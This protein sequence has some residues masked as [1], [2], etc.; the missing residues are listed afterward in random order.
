MILFVD[1]S[2]YGDAVF[3][4][5]YWKKAIKPSEV[6]S[7]FIY[8]SEKIIINKSNLGIPLFFNDKKYKLLLLIYK[9][10]IYYFVIIGVSVVT[11]FTKQ[12]INIIFNLHQPFK[13]WNLLLNFSNKRKVILEV[14]VHDV[15]EFDTSNYPKFIMSNNKKIISYS[16]SVILHSGFEVFKEIYGS[17]KELIQLPFP[18]RLP[19]ANSVPLIPTKYYYIP[20]RYRKEKGFDFVIKNWP[21]DEAKILVISTELPSDLKEEVLLNKNILYKPFLVESDQFQNLVVNSYACILMYNSGTNSG[22][23]ATIIANNIRCLVS[24]LNMFT[25]H[26]QSEK[27]IRVKLEKKDFIDKLNSLD[28]L[29]KPNYSKNAKNLAEY[30]MFLKSRLC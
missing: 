16:D 12:K 14:I 4:L 13:F 29:E 8:H 28:N 23:L 2:S 3:Y 17:E 1:F 10:L 22:V 6:S 30:E 9:F 27:F 15:I 7:F 20:G 26:S 11:Y 25:N 5:D 21:N 24:D 19:Y 18:T